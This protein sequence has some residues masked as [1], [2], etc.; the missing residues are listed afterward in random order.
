[1][2]REG[3]SF[4]SLCFYSGGKNTAGCWKTE[5]MLNVKQ[6]EKQKRPFHKDPG[7]WKARDFME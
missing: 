5:Q 3:L 7:L 4:G 1:M 2:N 6:I